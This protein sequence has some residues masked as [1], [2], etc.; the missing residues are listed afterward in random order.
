M[1]SSSPPTSSLQRDHYNAIHDDYDAHYGD[2]SSLEYRRRFFLD[3]LLKGIDLNGLE[4]ADLA[5][6]S[7]YTTRELLARFPRVKPVGFDIS[8]E[9]CRAYAAATGC[10]AHRLDLTQ[11][12]KVD[13]RFDAAIVIGGLH[14]CVNDLDIVIQNVAGLLRPGGLFLMV[15]PNRECWLEPLRRVWY[16]RDRYFEASTEAALSHDAMLRSADRLFEGVSASYGGGPAYFL[17]YNSLVMRI[18]RSAKPFIVAPLLQLE[19]WFN[20]LPGTAPF[21]FFVARWRRRSEAALS[22]KARR[23]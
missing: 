23:G 14:H 8:D 9:A 11:E 6:G 13:R 4:V 19:R 12:A 7:G 21:P 10:P 5:A 20:R 1:S 22:A 17:I 15:E 18:P 3:P 16:R 2:E